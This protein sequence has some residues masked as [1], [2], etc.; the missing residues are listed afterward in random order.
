M[1]TQ[2]EAAGLIVGTEEWMEQQE[3]KYRQMMGEDSSDGMQ[4]KDNQD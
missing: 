2:F 4:G 3:Q 1:Y